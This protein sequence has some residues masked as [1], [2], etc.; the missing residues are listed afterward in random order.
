M[1]RQRRSPGGVQPS[2]A[3]RDRQAY[4]SLERGRH[5]TEARQ[6]VPNP[7]IAAGSTVVSDWLQLFR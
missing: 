3:L 7:R 5:L 4:S 1:H 6:V 2:T